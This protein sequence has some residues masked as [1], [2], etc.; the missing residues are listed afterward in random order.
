MEIFGGFHAIKHL[1]TTK[2]NSEGNLAVPSAFRG[3]KHSVPCT[4]STL[5]TAATSSY[6]PKTPQERQKTKLISPGFRR[7]QDK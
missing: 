4:E 6:K 2:Y 1:L 3:R 5:S 7:S